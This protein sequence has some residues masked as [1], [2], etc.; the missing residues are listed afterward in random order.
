MT[1]GWTRAVFVGC[2]TFVVLGLAYTVAL[3]VLHR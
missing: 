2:V 1:V 3:G